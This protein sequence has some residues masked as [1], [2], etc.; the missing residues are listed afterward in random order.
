MKADLARCRYAPDL[1]QASGNFG[2]A[3][4]TAVTQVVREGSVIEK[5]CDCCRT[6]PRTIGCAASSPEA[7]PKA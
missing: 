1:D 6:E 5:L 3:I 2:R 7:G 4:Q